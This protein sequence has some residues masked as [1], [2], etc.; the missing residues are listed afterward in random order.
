ML[1]DNNLNKPHIP[2]VSRLSI[3]QAI[4]LSI[5]NTTAMEQSIMDAVQRTIL[6]MQARKDADVPRRLLRLIR[7]LPAT[8]DTTAEDG[9]VPQIDLSIIPRKVPSPSPL[10]RKL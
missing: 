3:Y 10:P 7:S 2:F 4:S 8:L 5:N 9:Q 6:E 1:E